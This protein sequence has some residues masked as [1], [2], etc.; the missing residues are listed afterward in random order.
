DLLGGEINWKEDDGLL[1]I[2]IFI[3][4]STIIN[5]KPLQ[6][7]IHLVFPSKYS[8]NPLKIIEQILFHANPIQPEWYLDEKNVKETENEGLKRVEIDLKLIPMKTGSLNFTLFEVI[9]EGENNEI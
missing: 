9:F 6:A 2:Q 7:N 3:S 4:D 5:H 1:S 8:I